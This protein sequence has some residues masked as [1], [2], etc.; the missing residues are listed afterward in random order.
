[1]IYKKGCKLLCLLKSGVS[2]S[3]TEVKGLYN[4][5]FICCFY[6]Y[7]FFLLL[8]YWKREQIGKYTRK[9]GINQ[10]VEKDYDCWKFHMQ[11]F[12]ERSKVLKWI[13]EEKADLDKV[14]CRSVIVQCAGDAHLE[15]INDKMTAYQMWTALENI[16]QRKGIASQIYLRKKLLMK[17]KESQSLGS[18]FIQFEEVLW[19]L[20]SEQN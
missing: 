18:Y 1:M 10:F 17:P 15:Y 7:Y 5:S 4:F 6:Y 8:Y 3:V 13:Q 2:K 12:L 11:V 20:K 19:E 16:F 9:Y 14:T